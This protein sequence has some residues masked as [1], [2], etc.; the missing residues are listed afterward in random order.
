MKKVSFLTVLIAFLMVFV[1]SACSSSKLVGF[2]NYDSK[3]DSAHSIDFP[4]EMVLESNGDCRVEGFT[5]SWQAKDG[6]ISFSIEWAGSFR[7][8]YKVSGNKLTL[9]YLDDSEGYVTYIKQ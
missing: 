5:G 2:W 4:E 9:F 6:I 1:V 3:S 8:N 7:Y